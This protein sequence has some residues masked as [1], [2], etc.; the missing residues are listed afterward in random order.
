MDSTHCK[1]RFHRRQEYIRRLEWGSYWDHD[2]VEAEGASH[3][4][5][6]LPCL[7]SADHHRSLAWDNDGL[8]HLQIHWLRCTHSEAGKQLRRRHCR[9]GCTQP[10]LMDSRKGRTH[11][12]RTRRATT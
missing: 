1:E 5:H 6:E 7:P 4:L 8:G 11:A 2:R 3:V 10:E 9:M 12:T